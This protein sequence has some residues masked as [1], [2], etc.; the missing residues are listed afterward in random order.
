M[1][2]IVKSVETQNLFTKYCHH[3]NITAIFLS[4]NFFAEGPC[5]RTITGWVRLIQTQ[6]IQS[7]T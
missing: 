5:V 2:Q 4:Q 6:L 1:E 3:Y 7:S